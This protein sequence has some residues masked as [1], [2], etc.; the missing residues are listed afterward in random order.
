MNLELLYKSEEV[1]AFLT[2]G[3]KELFPLDDKETVPK[4]PIIH[5]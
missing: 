1:K 4:G 5:D 3:I 2:A